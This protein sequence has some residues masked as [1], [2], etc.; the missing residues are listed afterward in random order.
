MTEPPRSM[1][2]VVLKEEDWTEIYYALYT[3]VG[4]LRTGDYGGNDERGDHRNS[5][6]S[7][8]RIM[9]AIGPDGTEAAARGVEPSHRFGPA[10]PP[11]CPRPP[12]CGQV[13]GYYH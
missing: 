7:L 1:R 5:A 6:E 10:S 9:D 12:S 4:T 2:P 3:R 13:S 11:P 8:E